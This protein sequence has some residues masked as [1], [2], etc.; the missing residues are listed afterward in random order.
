MRCLL[1]VSPWL[2]GGIVVGQQQGAGPDL[3]ETEHKLLSRYYRDCPSY[4]DTTEAALWMWCQDLQ[5]Q[6]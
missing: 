1:G 3:F 6:W 2:G 5:L 4:A